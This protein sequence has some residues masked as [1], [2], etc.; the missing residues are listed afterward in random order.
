MF[1]VKATQHV[2]AVKDLALTEGYFLDILGFSVR[3]R[4]GGWSFLS[5]G[6]FHVMLGHCPEQMPASATQD[7]AYCAYVNCA[8][9]E[10]LY[11]GYQQ[12]GADIFQLLADRPWGMRE[13]AV[14]TPDRHRIMFG[15]DI[16]PPNA[17]AEPCTG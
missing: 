10:D 4:V 8:D 12:R 15:E 14:A 1:E 5:L 2:L 9:I 13:F 16:D 7:H 11:R 6:S 3:S 17:S